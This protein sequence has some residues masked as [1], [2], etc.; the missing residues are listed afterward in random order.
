MDLHDTGNVFTP[1]TNHKDH[2]AEG[3]DTTTTATPD[4]QKATYSV[5]FE[6]NT[7]HSI[8]SALSQSTVEGEKKL[9]LKSCRGCASTS[10]SPKGDFPEM[11]TEKENKGPDNLKPGTSHAPSGTLDIPTLGEDAAK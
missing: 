11:E 3:I 7:M 2:S 1:V 8:P 4:F 6:D 10:V 5:S 9:S